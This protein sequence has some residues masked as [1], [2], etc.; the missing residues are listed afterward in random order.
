M[1]T[2]VNAVTEEK[3]RVGLYKGLTGYL[4]KALPGTLGRGKAEVNAPPPPPANRTGPGIEGT[5]ALDT[6]E[7][8]TEYLSRTPNLKPYVGNLKGVDGWLSPDGKFYECHYVDHLITAD[9][10]CKRYGYRMTRRFPY[11]LN[12]EYTLEI[13]G[14]VKISLGRVH[15]NCEKPMSKKQLDFLFDYLM[16]NDMAEEYQ[17]LLVKYG[18]D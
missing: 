12:G 7:E 1:E 5:S 3:K 14:W 16:A 8:T 13:N 9:K 6:V 10:L 11:Q 4:K 18:R 15:Y 17:G 2:T